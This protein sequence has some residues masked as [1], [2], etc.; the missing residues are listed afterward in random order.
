M[1]MTALMG[2]LLYISYSNAEVTVS[3]G[4]QRSVHQVTPCCTKWPIN[5]QCTNFTSMCHHNYHCAEK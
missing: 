3:G 1:S 4:G 2:E 5:D